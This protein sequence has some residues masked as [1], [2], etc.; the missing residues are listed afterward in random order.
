[1]HGLTPPVRHEVSGVIHC[2]STYS[3]GMEPLPVILAAANR[4]GAA[5]VLMTD[6]DTLAPLHEVGEQ[7]HGETLLLI[8]CEISPRHNHYLSYGITEPI[9]PYLPPPEYTAAV[10][11][12]GGIGFLAHPHDTGSPFLGQNSYSW[13]DWSVTQFTGIEIWNFFS[14]WVGSCR[15]WGSTLRALADWRYAVHAPD[16]ETLALW[17]EIGR[18]RRVT[19]IGG[20]DAHGIKRRIVGVDLVA[21]P[22]VRSFRTIRTH[23]MLTAPFTRDVTTDRL[24]VMEALRAGACFVANHQEGDP[25]GFTFVGR[26]ENEWLLMGQA[27]AHTGAGT[28]HFSTRVPYTF[29]TKPLLRLLK[30]GQVIAEMHDCDLQAADQGPGVYRV[31]ALKRGRGWIYS[32]PIYLRG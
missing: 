1:M 10:A 15:D 3:D 14:Q 31:E 28:V 6:H 11:A 5:F 17:D 23:L 27:V 18:E 21:H 29:G 26:R 24:L 19:A 30:D 22:Y 9:S 8:G 7:W 13:A 16:P 12:Q 32:N 20:V 2:H 25:T 4:S